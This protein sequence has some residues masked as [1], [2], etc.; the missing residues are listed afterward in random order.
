[1]A[2][3]WRCTHCDRGRLVDLGSARLGCAASGPSMCSTICRSP[4]PG[5][6]RP[7]VTAVP[8]HRRAV[9]DRDHLGQPVRDEEDRATTL[10]PVPHHREHALGE[11]GRQRRGDLVEQQAAADRAPARAR[12]RSCAAV[13]SGTSPACSRE[14]DRRCPSRAAA[15][16]TASTASP[17][18]RRFCATVR[19]GTSAGSWNTGASPMRAACGGDA[20]RTA[21]PRARSCRRRAGCTPVRILTNVLLPA[22]FAP[23]SAWTS[24]AL[25]REVRRRER[26]DRAVALAD[27]AGFEQRRHASATGQIGR[28]APRTPL[29]LALLPTAPCRLK[30]CLVL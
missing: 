25:D 11:I 23:S 19:S 29:P 22:P 20:T 28:G 9:A 1:M 30:S 15:R 26:D 7:D 16:L 27:L 4:P 14:V 21:L 13:G 8:Q 18:R 10:A 24:P 2:P 6:E 12:G 17:V 3:V 5:D